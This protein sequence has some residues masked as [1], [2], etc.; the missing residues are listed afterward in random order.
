MQLTTSRLAPAALALI[1]G[2]LALVAALQLGLSLEVGAGLTLALL[3]GAPAVAYAAS[4][5]LRPRQRLSS[6]FRQRTAA[7][8]TRRL[9]PR[10]SERSRDLRCAL[11]HDELSCTCAACQESPAALEE[12]A[13]EPSS[14]WRRWGLLLLGVPVG[15]LAWEA[16][17]LELRYAPAVVFAITAPIGVLAWRES[18]RPRTR[19]RRARPQRA[20]APQG[21]QRLR[22]R[23]CRKSLELV[24]CRSCSSLYHDS[25]QQELGGCAS[26]GCETARPLAAVAALEKRA[27]LEKR[28]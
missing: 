19:A 20:P 11:C 18:V 9:R 10:A 3:L 5:H 13:R 7:G 17:S 21:T 14:S 1:L 15:L 16:W 22:C 24:R 12:S 4:A 28:A 23:A 26:L 25:C 27:W 2:S 6:E 8:R